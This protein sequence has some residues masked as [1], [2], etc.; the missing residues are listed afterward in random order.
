[1]TSRIAT[2]VRGIDAEHTPL[3]PR[4]ERRHRSPLRRRRRGS[5]RPHAI[6]RT[7]HAGDAGTA[8]SR[9]LATRD[10][11][12]DIARAVGTCAHLSWTWC[13]LCCL[14]SA[15]LRAVEKGDSGACA[16][17]KSHLGGSGTRRFGPIFRR[18]QLAIH[19]RP[20][21]GTRRLRRLHT[22]SRTPTKD[23]G[24]ASAT[25]GRRSVASAPSGGPRRVH[26][27]SVSRVRAFLRVA[28][29]RRALAHLLGRHRR[30]RLDARQ[31]AR[32]AVRGDGARRVRRAEQLGDVYSDHDRRLRGVARG[33]PSGV[34]RRGSRDGPELE[35]FRGMVRA[36][37]RRARRA[38][39]DAHR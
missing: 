15:L 34:P 39:V 29:A 10:V 27:P 36:R 25:T 26:H 6:A 19:F 21:Y 23:G 8:A 32:R 35:R 37:R 24:V 4:L 22:P 3:N 5:A 18:F 33:L 14:D 28:R 16:P 30:S 13:L 31:P 38:A 20:N 7:T 2:G 11:M 12:P 1:M 17:L 9:A